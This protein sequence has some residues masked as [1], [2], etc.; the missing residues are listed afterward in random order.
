MADHPRISTSRHPR[1]SNLEISKYSKK[2]QNIPR[3]PRTSHQHNLW[4]LE[5]PM[6]QVHHILA[7]ANGTT[8]SNSTKTRIL[9]DGILT[10]LWSRWTWKNPDFRKV[11]DHAGW[12]DHPDRISKSCESSEII[13]NI[14][15]HANPQK[16]SITSHQHN[17][18]TVEVPNDPQSTSK[19]DLVS[20]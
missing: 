20:F 6:T 19:H 9:G 14:S 17:P 7:W 11:G 3:T 5:V 2:S 15:N 12:H 16:T 1:I 8:H 10:Y 18:L 13:D 4:Q